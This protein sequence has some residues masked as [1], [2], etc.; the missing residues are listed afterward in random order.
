MYELR[1]RE[2]APKLAAQLAPFINAYRPHGEPPTRAELKEAG[3]ERIE[4]ETFTD[5]LEDYYF[6]VTGHYPEDEP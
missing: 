3:Y 1:E 6:E 2:L 4:S 5:E